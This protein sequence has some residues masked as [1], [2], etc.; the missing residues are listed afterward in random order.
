MLPASTTVDAADF[1]IAF[2]PIT[3][4]LAVAAGIYARR[5]VAAG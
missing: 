2:V 5:L 3:I 1:F 4:P